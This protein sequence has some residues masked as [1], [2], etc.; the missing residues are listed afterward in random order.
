MSGHG[1]TRAVAALAALSVGTFLYVANE[2]LPIGLLLHMS[3]DLEVSPSAV[4]L[5]VT[6][7]GTVVVVA[8]IPLTLLTRRAP[9]RFLLSILLLGFVVTTVV[10]AFAASYW[11][12]FAAR[13]AGGLTH[14]L[15]WAVV[16]PTAAGLFRPEVRGRVVAVV[17]AGSSIA[18]LLGVPAGTWL[19]EVAGWRSAFLTLAVLGLLAL[20]AVATLLPTTPPDHGH[21][22]RGATPD[23][24]RY[25]LLI[26]VTV[27]ATTGTFAAYTYI[28]PFLTDISGF[29][30]AAT[31][32]L[33]LVRG[34]AS[35]LGIVAAARPHGP[36]VRRPHRRDGH[37]GARVG[38]G[39]I[40]PGSRRYLNRCQRRYCRRRAHRRRAP[41]GLRRSRRRTGRWDPEPGR[42]RR[43]AR[44]AVAALG[45]PPA[46]DRQRFGD[47][48]PA[49]TATASGTGIRS[50][51]SA[52]TTTTRTA[53]VSL[54]ETGAIR[55]PVLP[56]F[57][58]HGAS[59]APSSACG[60]RTWAP[61]AGSPTSTRPPTRSASGIGS[62][63]IRTLREGRF[64]DQPIRP[65]S[66]DL[67]PP[68]DVRGDRHHEV[69][70]YGI[71]VATLG[72]YAEPGRVVELAA[73]A[74]ATTSVRLG[75]AVTPLPRRRPVVLANAVAPLD[76]LSGGRALLGAG[77]GSVPVEFSA[78]G[79]PDD[80]RT[81]ADRLDEALTVMA[82][83]WS[84]EPVTHRGAHYRVDGVRLAP[85]PVQRPRPPIWIGGHSPA[86]RRRVA[87]WDGWIV[88]GMDEHGAMVRPP[89]QLAAEIADVRRGND[90][91]YDVALVG[92]SRGPGDP[93][94][95]RY[96]EAGVT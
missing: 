40:R 96:A 69:M 18:V 2:N 7:Y 26:V 89:A 65:T 84:G 60:Y 15:F 19:G 25:G 53:A 1:S 95:D 3:V 63:F 4:G 20:L 55:N 6:G 52:M 36:V 33:L 9:R 80:A 35:V 44:R 85:L 32:P 30:R 43:R 21:A 46:H 45:S 87:R 38:T 70:R 22:A 79:E 64:G 13:M 41:A 24:H 14:A 39:Q 37:P 73:V 42:P 83:L 90:L 94:F 49:T 86:A 88:S 28:A 16:V 74:Q 67:A 92:V 72:E 75:T 50:W 48:A 82:A 66:S 11:L 78:F 8:S 81:R 5:L 56:G 23:A 12:V 54:G 58:R 10:S 59:P 62:W 34:L 68:P 27:L 76:R 47:P 51:E 77:L 29:S 91:P 93:V 31:G 57:R 17:F 71:D 61:T